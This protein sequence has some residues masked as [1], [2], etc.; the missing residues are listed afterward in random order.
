MVRF[1]SCRLCAVMCDT[2][3]IISTT[4]QRHASSRYTSINSAVHGTRNRQ[5]VN[6]I[7]F[8]LLVWRLD[9]NP[10]EIRQLRERKRGDLFAKRLRLAD[11]A[12]VVQQLDIAACATIVTIVIIIIIILFLH[13]NENRQKMFEIIN[14]CN[15]VANSSSSPSQRLLSQF[16]LI[17]V[18]TIQFR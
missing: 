9:S 14:A 8:L 17:S 13:K 10:T 11:I 18:H 4:S 16:I 1:S 2:S 15:S 5:T 6:S 12:Y 7:D 3:S